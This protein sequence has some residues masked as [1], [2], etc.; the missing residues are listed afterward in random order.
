[1]TTQ[2]PIFGDAVAVKVSAANMR[3]PFEGCSPDYI[4]STCHGACCHLKS[5]PE[6]TRVR[7]EDDQKDALRARGAEFLGD[8]LKTIDRRCVFHDAGS[9]FCSL[10][11]TP[12]KPRS[13]IQSPFILTSRDV[14]IVRNRYKLLVC[15][16]AAPAIPAYRAFAS[17]LRLIFGP[18]EAA[19]LTDHFDAGGGDLYAVMPAA[20][21][22]FL[23][24]VHATW[25]TTT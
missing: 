24:D 25:A 17:A 21:Y 15:F 1:V 9:G 11:A 8:I 4:R 10:H 20:R 19:R 7:V 14:L 13:C 5:V 2:L 6:G 16:R 23:H 22:A 3:L 18:D 12:D